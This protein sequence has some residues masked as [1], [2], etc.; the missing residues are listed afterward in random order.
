ML[1]SL[2]VGMIVFTLLYVWLVLHRS[3]GLA[4]GPAARRPGP[5]RRDRRTTPRSGG[6]PRRGHRTRDRRVKYAQFVIRLRRHL[7]RRWRLHAAMMLRGRAS[8]A[9]RPPPRSNAVDLSP[10][11]VTDA[12]RPPSDGDAAAAPLGAVRRLGAR[13][14]RRAWCRHQVPQLRDRLLLQ[15]RRGRPQERAARRAALRIQGTVEDVDASGRD[16]GVAAFRIVQ[17]GV[18]SG[19]LPGREP[20]DLFQECIPVVVH[21]RLL[22]G[23]VRGR[24]DR[25][26]ALQQYQAKH[27]DRVPGRSPDAR[28][29]RR[30]HA[31]R[32][33]GQRHRARRRAAASTRSARVNGVL[34]RPGAG[35][36]RHR[37]GPGGGDPRCGDARR[38]LDQGPAPPPARRLALRAGSS[39]VAR[40]SPSRPWSGR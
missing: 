31:R 30:R 21:G 13:A 29:P 14:G 33:S 40:S 25:G 19:P 8:S 38:R 39:S 36:G 10:R 7:R 27:P 1:F 15:R 24:P 23:D 12:R 17:R 16:D 35:H 20:C 37:A 6:R 26:Q 28:P 34:R 9:E 22:S 32:Q 3:S 2:F 11:T 4:R 5:R 18:L